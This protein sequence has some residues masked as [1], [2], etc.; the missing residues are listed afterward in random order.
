[1]LR[2]PSLKMARAST[3][4]VV[5]PSPAMS[6]VLLATSFTSFAPMFSKRI[7]EFDFLAD[8][9]AVFGDGRAAE[10]LVDDDVAA[11]GPHRHR[12]GVGQLLDA[13]EHLGPGVI[14]KE[15]CF[16]TV[17][18]S[19]DVSVMNVRGELVSQVVRLDRLAS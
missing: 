14:F 4:A 11:G 12:D 15:N 3:V 2:R 17:C 9:D 16:A 1:M 13:L 8:G 18:D 19:F 7:F 10:G 6:E 5:V